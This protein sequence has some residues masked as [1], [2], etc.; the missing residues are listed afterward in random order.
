MITWG[1]CE[2]VDVK[3]P[4]L[5]QIFAQ[6]PMLHGLAAADFALMPLSGYTNR[7]FRLH[8][9]EH[10]WV[11]RIPRP[12]TD[13][14]IDREVETYNQSLASELGIAPRVLWRDASGLTLTATLSSSR[15]LSADDFN[16]DAMLQ[17]ILKPIRLLHQS[18]Q[19][20]L[21]RVDL[22]ELLARY[23]SMLSAP[24]QDPLN[25]RMHQ[26]QDRLA[27]LMHQDQPVVPSHN[28][29]VLENMLL[30]PQG[31]WLIDWE[32]SAMA[33]PY[34]DLATLCNAAQF[35]QTQSLRLLQAYCADG[36]LME[37]SVLYD[38]RSLLQ[39]LNDCWMAA[40]VPTQ[41]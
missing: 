22:A 12:D 34:W 6:I 3:P 19:P 7:N 41:P 10:D 37:E 29:L 33:S 31:L 4:D 17:T 25:A 20:F 11:L 1:R 14:H 35:D 2:G 30:D 24:R 23:F 26:A 27:R 40:F 5:D 9:D 21:G 36:R 38:Y 15:V 39:L 8:S 13:R 28:D 18:K 32:Y 16:D